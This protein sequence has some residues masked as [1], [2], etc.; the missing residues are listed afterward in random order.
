MPQIEPTSQVLLEAE[1]IRQFCTQ[2]FVAAGVPKDE[3]DIVVDV[4]LEAN[5]RGIDSHGVARIPHYLAR[6]EAGSIEPKPKLT[7]ERVAPS[8]AILDGGHGLGHLVMNRAAHEAI[9]L[10]RETGAGWVSV[11]NSSHCG[12]LA[13]PGLLMAEAGMIGLVFTH[14]DPMVL[15]HGARQPFC[16]TNPLCF[17]APGRNGQSLCLDMATSV[18]PW[19]SI[20]NARIEGMPI[21]MGWAVDAR[22]V[23]TTDPAK[24]AAIYPVG[25][26]KGSGLGLMIDVFCSLLSD[27]PF[28]PDIPKMYGDLSQR[29]LLGGLVGAIDIS[30]FVSLERFQDRVVEMICRWGRLKPAEPGGKV[31]YPGEP[32][33]IA[34]AKRLREGVP[35]GASLVEIF[36]G[37]AQRYNI[38]PL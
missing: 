37:L 33:M 6:M 7:I 19:N 12:A 13:H 28:G 16:G 21:P 9:A 1:H 38:N 22:G 17:T 35:L 14:V 10:A 11:R 34:R 24:V 36:N 4:L 8:S 29:R 27:G 30:R 3:A 25:G 2:L 15:P 32:E 26:Y 20:E 18:T 31:M 23:D 5:L